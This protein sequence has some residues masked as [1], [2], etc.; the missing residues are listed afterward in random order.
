MAKISREQ[1]NIDEMKILA[2]LQKHSNEPVDTIAKHCGFSRQK[3]WRLIKRLEES[4][5]IW[6]YTAVVDHQKQDLQKFIMSIKRSGKTLNK[7]NVDEIAV[8]RLEKNYSKMGITIESSYYGHGEYDWML[9]FTA[10]DLRQAKQF[11]DLLLG[12][13]P[14][15]VEKTSL[16]QILFTP[17]EHSVFNPNPTKLT[18]FI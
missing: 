12:S 2:E 9:L 6:G 17:R 7:K 11:S 10:K 13:Y 14:G 8:D 16:F 15:I 18:D 4:R 5:M 1:I 3:A